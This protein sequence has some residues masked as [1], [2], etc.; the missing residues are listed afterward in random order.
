MDILAFVLIYTKPFFLNIHNYSNIVYIYK[1][2][3][4]WA[5]QA[6]EKNIPILFLPSLSYTKTWVHNILSKMI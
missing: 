1:A 3:E 4:L 5:L 2:F 6:N